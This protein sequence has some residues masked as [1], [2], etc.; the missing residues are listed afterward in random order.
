MSIRMK[1]AGKAAFFH[2][3]GSLL[4]ASFAAVVVFGFWYPT[5]YGELSGGLRL[6]L[7]LVGVDVVCG[8]LLTL[9][10]FSP[11]KSRRELTLDMSLVVIVQLAALVYGLHTAFQGRPLYLVHELDRFRVI[12]MQDYLGEDVSEHLA[13]LDDALQ[14]SWS[15]GPITVGIRDPRD[16][17]ERQEVMLDSVTGGRDY[18]QRPEFYIPYDSAYSEKA[19]AQ[20]KPLPAFVEKYPETA[21]AAS[22][23]AKDNQTEIASLRFLPVLHRQEWIAVLDQQ[24]RILGFLPGDGFAVPAAQP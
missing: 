21:E 19:L 9:I 14:P 22:E 7:I 1:A 18:S 2:L 8:P 11:K 6:F 16:R 20:A 4:V 12:A 23:I 10:L 24:A 5:P 15:S 17:Q 3:I 13:K